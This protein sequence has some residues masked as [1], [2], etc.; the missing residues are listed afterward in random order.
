MRARSCSAGVLIV[1]RFLLP[2]IDVYIK[3][4]RPVHQSFRFPVCGSLRIRMHTRGKVSRIETNR[5]KKLSC[6]KWE[7]RAGLVTHL[8]AAGCR[9][10]CRRTVSLRRKTQPGS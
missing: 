4:G 7:G 9:R 10:L 8:N 1:E 5:K 3:R 6:T 2:N